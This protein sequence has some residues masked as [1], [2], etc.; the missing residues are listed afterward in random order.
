MPTMMAYIHQS[1]QKG[2]E[3][4]D[5]KGMLTTSTTWMASSKPTIASTFSAVPSFQPSLQPKSS[6]SIASAIHNPSSSPSSDNNNSPTP[7]LLSPSNSVVCSPPRQKKRKR[8]H[9]RSERLFRKRLTLKSL[10]VVLPPPSGNDCQRGYTLPL[11]P[12]SLIETKWLPSQDVL[13]LHHPTVSIIEKATKVTRIKTNLS[14]ASES[15]KCLPKMKRLP[16][17]DVLMFHPPSSI[18]Q[19]TTVTRSKTKPSKSLE[20]NI[21]TVSKSKPAV[22]APEAKVSKPK[23]SESKLSTASKGSA[24]KTSVSTPTPRKN[25]SPSYDVDYF[26]HSRSRSIVRF[27]ASSSNNTKPSLAQ[28]KRT[29]KSKVEKQRENRPTKK[30]RRARAYRAPEP[31]VGQEVEEIEMNTGSLYLYRGG[32]LPRRAVFILY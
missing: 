13:T 17:Q 12:M 15:K 23:S 31:N 7:Q 18:G 5:L 8:S 21:C 9:H 30:Q 3:M 19:T 1:P 11:E 16:S 25:F 20:S 24:S 28:L 10:G 32:D 2:H 29:L 14:Q 26:R 22:S 6:P 27:S 4:D